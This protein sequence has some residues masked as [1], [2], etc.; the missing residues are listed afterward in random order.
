MIYKIITTKYKLSIP[1]KKYIL[2]I[3]LYNNKK[4]KNRL[5]AQKYWRFP[6]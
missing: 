2:I 3:N 1:L 5:I 4:V 6:Y